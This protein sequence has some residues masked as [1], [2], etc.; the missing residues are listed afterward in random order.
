MYESLKK[1][2]KSV[3]PTALFYNLKPVLRKAVSLFYRGNTNF[4]NICETNLRKFISLPNGTDLLCPACGSLARHRFLLHYLNI[5]GSLVPNTHILDFS[6]AEGFKKKLKSEIQL[7]YK[8]SN[9]KS[10]SEDFDFDITNILHNDNGFDTVICF[11]VL[12]HIPD[13]IKAMKE[14]FRILKPGGKVL[15]QVPLKDGEIYEDAS[16]TSEKERRKHF[17]Q[18]D[19]VRIYSLTGLMERLQSVGFSLSFL[20]ASEIYNNNDLSKFGITVNEYILLAERKI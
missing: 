8:T 9:Y 5:S 2:T 12:E 16:I 11:H 4:C 13:D 19:H 3:L 18:E 15:I 6:P 20:R 14:L 17:G 7:I 10:V 1:V